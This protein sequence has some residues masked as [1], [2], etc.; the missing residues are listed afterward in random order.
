MTFEKE[1]SIYKQLIPNAVF[2]PCG[3]DREKAARGEAKPWKPA[4]SSWTSEEVV[5]KLAE[6]RYNVFNSEAA[7]LGLLCGKHSNVTILDF[8]DLLVFVGC[9]RKSRV[10]NTSPYK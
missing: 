6:K 8:D 4:V 7:A 5:K 9:R 1:F 3:V 10:F 2:I